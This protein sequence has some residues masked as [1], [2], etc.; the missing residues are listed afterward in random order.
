MA[1]YSIIAL[2]AHAMTSDIDKCIE[3]GCNYYLQAFTQAQL[4]DVLTVCLS[5]KQN[6]S[7]I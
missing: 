5:A 4:H 2:T 7:F 1:E 6:L 3:A